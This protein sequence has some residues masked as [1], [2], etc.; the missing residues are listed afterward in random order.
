M[1]NHAS[2]SETS[3]GEAG[4]TNPSS[5]PPAPPASQWQATVE[6]VPLVKAMAPPTH[7]DL[8]N[9]RELDGR[10]HIIGDTE[11]AATVSSGKTW[12]AQDRRCTQCDAL[13]LA[14][15]EF[16]DNCGREMV[17]DALLISQVDGRQE[18]TLQG[19]MRDLHDV[20]PQRL[21]RC[22]RVFEEHGVRF[23]VIEE[24]MFRPAVTQW[25]ATIEVIEEGIALLEGLAALKRHGYRLGPL[26]RSLG[27][28]SGQL[29]FTPIETEPADGLDDGQV[30]FPAIVD[31]AETV[32][33]LLGDLAGKC[34]LSRADEVLDWAVQEL[35]QG[36]EESSLD[37]ALHA[38][39]QASGEAEH[40]S[41]IRL[42]SGHVSSEGVVRKGKPDED[43][44]L[45]VEL[46]QVFVAQATPLGFY[47][48]ADGMGGH[49][50]GEVASRLALEALAAHV[51]Q[52]IVTP[53]MNGTVLSR[54][55]AGKALKDAVEA[56]HQRVR[57]G[58]GDSDTRDM[59][60]T[61][62]AALVLDG[63]LYC[64]NV[65]DSR[66]YH[67][68]AAHRLLRRVSRDHSVV[69]ELVDKGELAPED[70]YTDPRRNVVLASLGSP[71]ELSGVDLFVEKIGAGDRLLLCSDG[72]WE[73]VWDR[74]LADH[75][76][77]ATDPQECAE[78][79]VQL[80]CARGGVDNTTC[81]V[82][83]LQERR[84]L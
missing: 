82:V 81:I 11:N 40:T 70:V 84:A 29:V 53:W 38:L 9:P 44:A 1:E 54:E 31:T 12:L 41:S 46:T 3:V 75:L 77:R 74:E 16:C 49:D 43:S 32:L 24:G 22:R 73:L 25:K 19:L 2:V 83:H 78:E 35:K 10:Y 21:L 72:L 20:W 39:H 58:G 67:Y 30:H 42:L 60:T 55:T 34:G 18:A 56:A 47:A 13:N 71:Q 8:Q 63:M 28:M 50:A 6:E 15:D 57:Q 23:A 65:G 4:T 14:E 66:T 64:V 68:M 52:H 7:P 51:L 62:T 36:D 69:Q 37:A 80:A 27:V 17:R 61:L 45:V 33:Q 5:Q 26:A 76:E 59:G 48:V 79:L